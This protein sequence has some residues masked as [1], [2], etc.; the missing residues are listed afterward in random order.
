MQTDT[1]ANVDRDTERYKW[2]CNSRCRLQT[3]MQIDTYGWRCKSRCRKTQMQVQIPMQTDT[4]D[5][6]RCR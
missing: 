5:R 2:T 6:P 4:A 3:P 1:D